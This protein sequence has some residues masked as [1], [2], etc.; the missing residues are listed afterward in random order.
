MLHAL[1]HRLYCPG[2]ATTVAESFEED[3]GDLSR[4]DRWGTSGVAPCKAT[5]EVVVE[6]SQ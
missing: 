6:G 4:G 2:V 3:I 5:R 1:I